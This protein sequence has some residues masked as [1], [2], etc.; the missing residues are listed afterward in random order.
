MSQT[1]SGEPRVDDVVSGHGD[2][3]LPTVLAEISA[4]VARRRASGEFPAGLERELDE[5]FARYAPPGALGPV[6]V[7][8]LADRAERAAIIDVAVP[9]ADR[10]RWVTLVKR[11]LRKSIA[12]YL[13]FVG[14][15]VGGAIR[16]VVDLARRLDER[17]TALEEAVP[18]VDARVRAELGPRSPSVALDRWSDEVIAAFAE[19]RGPVVVLGAHDDGT[20]ARRLAA[21]GVEATE[22]EDGDRWLPACQRGDERLHL[23]GLAPSS[24]SGAVVA[25]TAERLPPGALVEL[26]DLLVDRVG[27]GGLLAVVSRSPRPLADPDDWRADLA[28]ERP[29]QPGTWAHLL[30]TRG[31][32]VEVRRDGDPEQGGRPSQSLPRELRPA[33]PYLVLARRE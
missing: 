16:L 32:R 31:F 11:L 2:L 15:Q 4:E 28:P 30:T 21:V 7:A 12:W 5:A 25:G 23:R 18:G 6:G 8:V 13:D 3:D 9:V 29:L 22:P 19:V 33:G 27:P 1:P 26:A 20:L 17:V 10:R 14:K 24:L